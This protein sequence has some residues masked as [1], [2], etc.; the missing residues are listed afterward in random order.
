[1][2]LYYIDKKKLVVR[3]SER[4]LG[5]EVEGKRKEKEEKKKKELFILKSAIK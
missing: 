5:K 4:T 3:R 2:K 1:M